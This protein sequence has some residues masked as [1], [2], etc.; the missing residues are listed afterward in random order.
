MYIC[1]Y[2]CIYIHIYT[3]TCIHICMHV[4]SIYHLSIY[5][6]TQ[7]RPPNHR[8]ILF[9][10]SLPWRLKRPSS[11]E[12][13]AWSAMHT[14]AR[15]PGSQ[16]RSRRQI[17]TKSR[18]TLSKHPGAGSHAKIR[19]TESN[20]ASWDFRSLLALL[21]YIC[22]CVYVYLFICEYIYRSI[23]EWV[24]LYVYIYLSIHLYT[25]IYIYIFTHTL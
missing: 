19:G 10:Q 3:Y 1:M 23:Y 9:V 12:S 18:C 15:R 4:Y 7:A 5:L 22:V 21:V 6:L 16:C 8:L 14:A 11:V 20:A 2:V 25:Y 17:W 13:L 24:C